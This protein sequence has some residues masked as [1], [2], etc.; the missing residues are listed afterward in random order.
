MNKFTSIGVTANPIDLDTSNRAH[1][2]FH[3]ILNEQHEQH[4]Q[5]HRV[6][7]TPKIP[8]VTTTRTAYNVRWRIECMFC[9]H[10]AR[11]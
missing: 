9:T 8:I 3:G 7:D 5:Q 1:K 4:E 2:L 11:N 10:V 6:L